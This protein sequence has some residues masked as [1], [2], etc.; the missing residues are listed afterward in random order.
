MPTYLRRA[1]VYAGYAHIYRVDNEELGF[2]AKR[3]G[4]VNSSRNEL[5]NRSD[6]LVYVNNIVNACVLQLRLQEQQ[7]PLLPNCSGCYR[8]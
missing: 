1:Y 4:C 6:R 2:A 3:T 7:Y 8:W 5:A